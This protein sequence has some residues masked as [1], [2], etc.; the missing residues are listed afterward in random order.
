M[1][2]IPF[3]WYSIAKFVGRGEKFFLSH[4]WTNS[5]LLPVLVNS[6][7]GKSFFQNKR[8]RVNNQIQCDEYLTSHILHYI[9]FTQKRKLHIKNYSVKSAGWL[10]FV[11]SNLYLTSRLKIVC[12]S[13]L[14]IVWYWWKTTQTDQ[15]LETLY[16][17][18]QFKVTFTLCKNLVKGHNVCLYHLL[19]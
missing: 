15:C 9:Q 8:T 14:F 1:A 13:D 4:V 7:P 5:N 19:P 16:Q 10:L 18:L 17:K 6:Y 3:F 2:P 12:W 11:V